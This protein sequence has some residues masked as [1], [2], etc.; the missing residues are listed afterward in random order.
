MSAAAQPLFTPQPK[1]EITL[2]LYDDG[3]RVDFS[4]L[5]LDHKPLL[6]QEVRD[7]LTSVLKHL[8]PLPVSGVIRAPIP[9]LF[10]TEIT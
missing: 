6:V 1:L 5:R 2:T 3:D 7:V 9:Q 8:S 10:P 4:Y